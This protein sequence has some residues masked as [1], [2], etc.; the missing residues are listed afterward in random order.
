MPYYTDDTE[1]VRCA[2]RRRAIVDELAQESS[3]QHI[4]LKALCPTR[5]TVRAASRRTLSKSYTLVQNVL[6]VVMD[7]KGSRIA[8]LTEVYIKWRNL[9]VLF[10]LNLAQA[11]FSATEQVSMTMQYI[12]NNLQ[13]VIGSIEINLEYF[14]HIRNES[15]CKTFHAGVVKRER[16]D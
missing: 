6:Q 10:S 11:I 13:E 9:Q 5:Y 8:K 7:I 2:P 15:N 14:E 1:F 12:F 4:K 3:E 16:V